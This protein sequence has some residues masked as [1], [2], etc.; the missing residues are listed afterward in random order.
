[1]ASA[2]IVADVNGGLKLTPFRRVEN[3]PL[4]FRFRESDEGGLLRVG[5]VA[6]QIPYVL[7]HLIRNRGVLNPIPE[8]ER[9]APEVIERVLCFTAI[10]GRYVL[11]CLLKLRNGSVH[12]V[13]VRAPGRFTAHRT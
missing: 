11:V 3:Y 4:V 8:V 6:E 12:P 1:L 9:I 13:E 2:A 7:L 10:T 5:L